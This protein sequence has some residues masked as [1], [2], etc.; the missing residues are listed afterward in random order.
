MPSPSSRRLEVLC[1]S[2]I[3]LIAA[4][5]VLVLFHCMLVR[6]VR[7]D[8]P[9]EPQVRSVHAIDVRPAF[10][11][12]VAVQREE[13]QLVFDPRETRPARLQ[14]MRTCKLPRPT[15]LSPVRLLLVALALHTDGFPSLLSVDLIRQNGAC[16]TGN[17]LAGVTA[18]R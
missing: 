10:A 3:P 12:I 2:G 6:I 16:P 4:L 11:S 8:I 7:I 14:A 18:P 1:Q 5:E 13:K 17:D 15:R 9:A